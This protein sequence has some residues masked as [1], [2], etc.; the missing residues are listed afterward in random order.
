MKKFNRFFTVIMFIFLY[1]PMAVLVVASFNTGKDLTQF[2]GFTLSQYKALFQDPRIQATLFLLSGVV[3]ALMSGVLFEVTT[4]AFVTA[5]AIV[6]LVLTIRKLVRQK[7]RSGEMRGRFFVLIAVQ[8]F[9][10]V[11]TRSMLSR[12]LLAE[13]ISERLSLKPM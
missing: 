13:M 2:E 7:E 8:D 4:M 1:A 11:F 3:L 10:S 12:S 5:F 6:Q 9:L